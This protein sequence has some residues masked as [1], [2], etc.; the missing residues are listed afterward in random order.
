ML[1]NGNCLD[2]LPKIGDQSIN[3]IYTDPPYKETGNKWDNKLVDTVELFKH[4]ERIIKVEVYK[5]QR[6]GQMVDGVVTTEGIYPPIGE[7][8]DY[9][10]HNGVDKWKTDMIDPI[11]AKYPKPE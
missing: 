11:K 9:I 4:Y 2:I 10:Y 7:Q 1:V 8:L 6:T 5:K 3:L